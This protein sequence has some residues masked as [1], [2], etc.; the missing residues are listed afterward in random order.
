[1][2]TA[3]LSNLNNLS[4]ATAQGY[5]ENYYEDRKYSKYPT[6]DYKYECQKGTFEGFFVSSVE[7]CKFEFN[8]TRDNETGTQCPTG[9]TGSVG[10]PG[11]FHILLD[12]I[13]Q[14]MIQYQQA[15][16]N[17][18]SLLIPLREGWIVIVQAHE[19][20]TSITQNMNTLCFD[21]PP[22]H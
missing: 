17:L 21:N 14:I 22:S 6:K 3:A 16:I 8:D 2:L 10:L 4:N 18:Q 19:L 15:L 1:M 13:L 12:P 11:P 7:F 20:Y 9:P 5:N